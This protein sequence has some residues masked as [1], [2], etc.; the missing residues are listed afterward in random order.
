MLLRTKKTIGYLFFGLIITISCQRNDPGPQALFNIPEEINDGIQ[1]GNAEELGF[2]PLDLSE[3]IIL[4]EDNSYTN[5]HS[6][7][8]AKDNI[9][10]FEEYFP[11]YPIYG[12]YTDWNKSESHNLHSVTKSF[13]S[14]LVGIAVDQYDLDITSTVRDFF[15][16]IDPNN[17][18]DGKSEITVEHLLTMSSGL[19]WDEWTYSYDDERND[20][21]Q[22]YLYENW[23]HF[24]LQ[25]PLSSDPGSAFLYNSGL[26]ITLGEI[27]SR[28]TGIGLG[29]FASNHLFGPLGINGFVWG[30]KNGIYQAGGSLRM[31]P[32][33][34]LKF[35][36]LFLNEGVWNDERLISE[37]WVNNSTRQQGPYPQYGYQWWLR[38]YPIKGRQNPA[39]M[40][41]GR[42]GQY[43]IVIKDVNVVIVFT[44]GNDNSL[45]NSQTHEIVQKYILPGLFE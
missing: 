44:A 8:I 37:D 43:I 42:G 38:N 11:G 26:S 14:A 1:V 3:I 33:D 7:L 45:A 24:V 40:A 12:S 17:W 18:S 19:E 9:L 23:V 16:E 2:S 5:I 6:I 36:L 25:K 22:M 28:H 31:K 20:H 34:M 39:Y 10:V 27:V 4:V 13:T 21:A 35:G 32:R 15:P 30:S 41:A 29:E